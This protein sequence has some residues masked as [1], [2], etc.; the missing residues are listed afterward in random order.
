MEFDLKFSAILFEKKW[1]SRSLFYAATWAI[2]EKTVYLLPVPVAHHLHLSQDEDS[3][4]NANNR[5]TSWGVWSLMNDQQAHTKQSATIDNWFEHGGWQQCR[6]FAT[7]HWR[8]SGGVQRSSIKC[9]RQVKGDECS[10]IAFSTFIAFFILLLKLSFSQSIFIHSH[11]SLPQAD[12][13]E[14]WLHRCF[15][16]TGGGSIGKCSRLSKPSWV[17][18]AL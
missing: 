7:L 11:L 10:I 18:C 12:P 5:R 4:D 14:S 15:A 17:L 6:L 9:T 8:Q 2:K 16:L 1:Q 3:F 13:Q